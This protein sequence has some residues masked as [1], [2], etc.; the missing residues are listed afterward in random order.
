MAAGSRWAAN[1]GIEAINCKKFPYNID[2]KPGCARGKTD[3]K[4]M[5]GC[6]AVIFFLAGK[7]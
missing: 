4:Q 5:K 6:S 2:M 7:Q 3:I 1:R